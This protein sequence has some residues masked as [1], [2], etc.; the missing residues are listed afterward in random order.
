MGLMASL[1]IPTNRLDFFIRSVEISSYLPGRIRLHSRDL[2][3]NPNLEQEIKAS[4][5]PLD[6]I[7]SVETSTVTGSILIKYTP[8]QLR[9]N[10]E[11]RKVEEYIMTHARRK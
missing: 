1:Q 10:N 3:G 5:S 2:V 9:R 8:E 4:L 6:G 11:L 7:D